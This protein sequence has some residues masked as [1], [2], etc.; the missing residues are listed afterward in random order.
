MPLV[1]V[2]DADG[3]SDAKAAATDVDAHADGGAELLMLCR[4]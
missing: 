1:T 2:A 4:K 3:A